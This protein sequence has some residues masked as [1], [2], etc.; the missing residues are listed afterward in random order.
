MP[1]QGER[2]YTA[3][4]LNRAQYDAMCLRAALAARQLSTKSLPGH[5]VFST[6]HSGHPLAFTQLSS[7]GSTYG[8]LGLVKTSRRAWQVLRRSGVPVPQSQTF[9]PHAQTAAESYALRI[10]LPVVVS[11]LTGTYRRT[12]DSPESLHQAVAE[13]AERVEDQ[14]LVHS[15]VPGELLRLMVQGQQV[16]AVTA[17]G[18]RGTLNLEDLD[19][20]LRQLAAAAVKAIPGVDT[21]AV[22]LSTPRLKD[23][24]AEKQALVERVMRSPH[25]RDFAAGSRSQALRLADQV[26]Q[27]A[28]QEIG[29]VL[30]EP[31]VRI[32]AELSFTGVPD[33]ES[34]TAELAAMV[35]AMGRVSV[36]SEPESVPDGAEMSIRGPASDVGLLITRSIAGFAGGDSAHLVHCRPAGEA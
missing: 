11:S 9:G 6:G 29:L 13:V 4:S 28:A 24:D 14:L 8:G 20:S 31:L 26:V 35:H 23:V 34:F 36:I 33:P 30:A 2:L 32:S 1:E 27:A 16:L 15:T 7:Y 5:V 17:Q 10:G 22:T 18:H 19:P 21:A 25:L 12:A 3:K